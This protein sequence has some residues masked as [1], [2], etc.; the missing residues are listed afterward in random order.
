MSTFSKLY[1][2]RCR[3]GGLS[4]AQAVT[5]VQAARTSEGYKI[6]VVMTSSLHRRVSPSDSNVPSGVKKQLLCQYQI[7][8]G[9]R[10]IAL[11][12]SLTRRSAEILNR[13]MTICP[14]VSGTSIEG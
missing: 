12:S 9:I 13:R 4:L 1:A 8:V 5:M 14:L 7:G 6:D 11:L 2:G 3:S 10:G